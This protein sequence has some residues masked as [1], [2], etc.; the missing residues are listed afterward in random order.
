MSGEFDDI[1]AVENLTKTNT[2]ATSNT[3]TWDAA[4]LPDYAEL[5]RY[6]IYRD[7]DAGT[8]RADYSEVGTRDPGETEFV[9]TGLDNGTT[10]HYRVGAD[11]VIPAIDVDTAPATDVGFTEATLNG[12]LVSLEDAASADVAFEYR[13]AGGAWTS[14]PAQTLASPQSYDELLTGLSQGTEYEARATGDADGITDTGPVVDWTTAV[15]LDHVAYGDASG[16]VHVHDITDWSLLYSATGTGGGNTWDGD[17]SPDGTLLATGDPNPQA[18]VF[19]T[20]DYSLDETPAGNQFDVRAVEFSPGGGGDLAIGG[21]DGYLHVYDTSSWSAEQEISTPYTIADLDYSSGG[22]YVALALDDRIRIYETGNWT[23]ET[24]LFESS[25]RVEGVAFSPDG[26]Y[27]AHGGLDDSVYVHSVPDWTLQQSLA[28]DGRAANSVAFSPASD[29]IAFSD[30]DIVTVKSTSDWSDV[31]TLSQS[32]SG[33][34]INGVAFSAD[35]SYVAAASSSND[36]YIHNTSNW[37][38]E[39]TLSQASDSVEWVTF[40]PA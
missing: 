24:G 20:T 9:D 6:R 4:S 11:V 1:V 3:L 23:I 37:L 29:Y 39:Q 26:Q 14:T 28:V 32:P 30:D 36:V 2:T 31:A 40:S 5:E 21:Q 10:Y 34:D 16:N 38:L 19:A 18:N 7:T 22:D 25:S 12:E 8:T 13:E 35:G 33:D 27:L 17:Y 15:I